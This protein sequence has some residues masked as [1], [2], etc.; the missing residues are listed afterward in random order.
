MSKQEFILSFEN[1]QKKRY[2]EFLFEYRNYSIIDKYQFIYQRD[3]VSLD[4]EYFKDLVFLSKKATRSSLLCS[5]LP[6][7]H[8]ENIELQNNLI[9]IKMQKPIRIYTIINIT[10]CPALINIFATSFM[11][12]PTFKHYTSRFENVSLDRY[13]DDFLNK[14]EN[15]SLDRVSDDRMTILRSYFTNKD[16]ILDI[17]KNINLTNNDTFTLNIFEC[18]PIVHYRI[19]PYLNLF[20]NIFLHRDN[21]LFVEKEMFLEQD[22]KNLDIQ[23]DL[24]LTL[25]DKNITLY[26]NIFTKNSSGTIVNI[27]NEAFFGKD[28]NRSLYRFENITSRTEGV[29]ARYYLNDFA[30]ENFNRILNVFENNMGI[31]HGYILNHFENNNAYKVYTGQLTVNKIDPFRIPIKT[32]YINNISAF[33]KNALTYLNYFNTYAAFSMNGKG[34]IAN[35]IEAF[36]KDN[37]T[38]YA[39]QYSSFVQNSNK[40]LNVQDLY[41][42][43]NKNVHTSLSVYDIIPFTKDI[44]HLYLNSTDS[45]STSSAKFLFDTVSIEFAIKYDANMY[46]S[47][48]ESF[49]LSYKDL[50]LHTG[51]NFFKDVYRFMFIDENNMFA[52]MS[53]KHIYTLFKQDFADKGYHWIK[54]YNGINSVQKSKKAFQIILN[55]NFFEKKSNKMYLNQNKDFFTKISKGIYITNTHTSI[56]KQSKLTNHKLTMFGLD[57]INHFLQGTFNLI[58]SNKYYKNLFLDNTAGFLYKEYKETSLNTD[59]VSDIFKEY[60]NVDDQQSVISI[61]KVNKPMFTSEIIDRIMKHAKET[62]VFNTDSLLDKLIKSTFIQENLI[63]DKLMHNADFISLLNTMVIKKRIQTSF[64]NNDI[65]IDKLPSGTLINE[66]LF[67]NK[68]RHQILQENNISVYRNTKQIC[69]ENNLFLNKYLQAF[70]SSD[71]YVTRDSLALDAFSQEWI[72]TMRYAFM[73]QDVT[74]FRNLQETY[75]DDTGIWTFKQNLVDEFDQEFATIDKHIKMYEALSVVRTNNFPAAF[76]DQ[77]F[78]S[79]DIIVNTLPSLDEIHKIAKDLDVLTNDEIDWAW[80]YQEDEGFD[81]PFKIDELL[82]PENDSRYEDFE[83]ILFNRK[84]LK[85]RNP[86]QIIDDY[87][88]IAKYPNH[89]PIK[90]ENGENAYK[91]IAVEYLDVRTSIMR[92]VFIGYYKLWQDH[93]FEFSR[94]TIPQSAKTILDYLYVWILMSFAEEDIPEALRVFRQVRWYLER[95]IIECSEYYIAYEPDDLTSGKLDNTNLEIPSDLLPP[96]DSIPQNNTMYIDTNRHIITNNPNKLGQEAHITFYID[97]NKDT[98]ISF[99]LHTLTPVYIILNEG[100]PNETTLDTITLPTTGKMVYNIPYTG[101]TNTFTIKKLGADNHDNDFFIGNIVIVGMGSNGNL[102]INFNPKIQGNK[103]L[104]HVSQ[105]VIAYMNLYEDN[106][107]IINELIKGNVHLSEVY[108]KLLTYWDLHWQDKDKG[109]RLTIKRT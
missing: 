23:D 43:V 13:Y 19:K 40:I 76:Y 5:Y 52:N 70:M 73:H 35:Q 64:F 108:E 54:I 86:V 104:N 45:F 109:K 55:T 39:D 74:T 58:F 34:L 98:T 48:I 63:C 20:D 75:A 107:K 51:F 106:E 28:A 37:K 60:F 47:E 21:F 1:E 95:G 59:Y 42:A 96:Y 61:N 9:R 29:T 2:E 94:M 62:E 31:R 6:I 81:D 65:F 33:N 91:N 16:F 79:K 71:V 68:I 44:K 99:S 49:T 11:A 12:Y 15:I 69:Y 26:D 56:N 84:T 101:D 105:K 88:F 85:P 4:V 24:F 18:I 46:M 3:G 67:I 77:Y 27:F 57:K 25:Q 78:L 66:T 97:N 30:E 41:E 7:E 89:Y 80:V 93:I 53:K 8:Q 90:D 14:L 38:L 103:V 17:Y 32:L 92:K 102:E 36:N 83:D 72:T 10:K 82:L 87:T 50:S 100:L 22:N